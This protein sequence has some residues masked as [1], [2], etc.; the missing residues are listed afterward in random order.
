MKKIVLSALAL[1]F[2]VT[3]N[4]SHAAAPAKAAL[5]VAC[6]GVNGISNQDIYPNLAG[7]KKGYLVLSLKGYRDGTRN[8][9]IMKG[10][11]GALSDQDIEDLAEYYSNLK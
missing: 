6:H 9:A 2:A 11:A 1:T 7:Q 3:L 5:C 8:N 4:I 10:M